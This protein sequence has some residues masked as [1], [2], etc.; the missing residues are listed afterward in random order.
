[1]RN[2]GPKP[3]NGVGMVKKWEDFKG[4]GDHTELL[5]FVEKFYSFIN[6]QKQG[7]FLNKYTLWWASQS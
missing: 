1:M 5:F 3:I 6:V 2:G 7:G 4:W